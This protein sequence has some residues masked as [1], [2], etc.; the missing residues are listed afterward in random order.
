M[1]KWKAYRLMT[2]HAKKDTCFTS[3]FTATEEPSHRY[4]V[5]LVIIALWV[6]L[7]KKTPAHL[8]HT[9]TKQVYFQNLDTVLLSKLVVFL[10]SAPV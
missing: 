7:T 9:I 3:G 6:P 5:K 1:G 8:V 4:H 10:V 2:D